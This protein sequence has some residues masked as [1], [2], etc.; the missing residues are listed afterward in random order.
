MWKKQ[1]M[2]ILYLS[3]HKAIK[4]VKKDK[5]VLK[6]YDFPKGR[7]LFRKNKEQYKDIV[8]QIM[9][10]IIIEDD[11]ESIGGKKEMAITDVNTKL[12]RRIKEIIVKE[13][14]GIDNFPDKIHDLLKY[15]S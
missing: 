15:E 8:E 5:F 6:K 12:K 11:C 3:S 2:E 7:I 13:F 9:P 4:D 14:A 10:D 1:G